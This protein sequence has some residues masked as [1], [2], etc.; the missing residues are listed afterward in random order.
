LTN[1]RYWGLNTDTGD[2]VFDSTLERGEFDGR[3]TLEART[4]LS[5]CKSQTRAKLDD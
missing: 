3:Q 4:D 5:N 2:R 1:C